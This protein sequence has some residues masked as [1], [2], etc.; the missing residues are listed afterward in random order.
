[1]VDTQGEVGQFEHL[2]LVDGLHPFAE[3]G[4][5]ARRI[6]ASHQRTH[7]ATGNGAYLISLGQQFLDNADVHQASR[8]AARKHQRHFLPSVL[9]LHIY[10]PTI[11]P[12]NVSIGKYH[13]CNALTQCKDMDLSL[14]HT[15]PHHTF[16]HE[17]RKL[18]QKNSEE[19]LQDEIFFAVSGRTRRRRD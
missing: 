12:A 9:L 11:H 8:T 5:T 1:M 2:P 17:A 19:G 6:D 13:T 3:L 16:Y 18:E 7:R 14:T 4:Q 10:F 15:L